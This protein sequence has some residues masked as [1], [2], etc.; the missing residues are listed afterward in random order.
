MVVV[1][2]IVKE[3]KKKTKKKKAMQAWWCHPTAQPKLLPPSPKQK[4]RLQRKKKTP[5]KP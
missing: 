4:A 3:K 1:V 2:V 5:S